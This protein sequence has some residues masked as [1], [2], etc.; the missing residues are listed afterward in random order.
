MNGKEQEK[1]SGRGTH[2]TSDWRSEKGTH[3]PPLLMN[4]YLTLTKFRRESTSMKELLHGSSKA[5]SERRL[6]SPEFI[7]CKLTIPHQRLMPWPGG[8]CFSQSHRVQPYQTFRPGFSWPR[9]LPSLA[10]WLLLTTADP[11]QET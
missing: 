10:V 9:L 6:M 5:A 4:F 1:L 7:S 3:S 2:Q 8:Y 11:G